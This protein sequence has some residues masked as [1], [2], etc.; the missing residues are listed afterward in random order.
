MPWLRHSFATAR[1]MPD[2]PPV[3]RAILPALKTGWGGMVPGMS[4]GGVGAGFCE[5][6]LEWVMFDGEER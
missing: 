2:A 5:L 4:L 6:H 3:I 1:P